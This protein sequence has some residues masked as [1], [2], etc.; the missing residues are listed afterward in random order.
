VASSAAPLGDRR[1]SGWGHERPKDDVCV[2]SVRLP[3]ADIDRRGPWVA[4]VPAGV[5]ALFR[6][7][8]D[9]MWVEGT[10]FNC[11]QRRLPINLHS[12]TIEFPPTSGNQRPCRDAG[13]RAIA[14]GLAVLERAKRASTLIQQRHLTPSCEG[15]A[16]TAERTLDPA[17]MFTESLNLGPEL[18]NNQDPVRHWLN[19][20][21]DPT[22]CCFG[23]HPRCCELVSW[24]EALSI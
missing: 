9:R 18:E 20:H 24:L 4:F 5:V 7:I 11:H 16:P 13:V 21:C 6:K 12:R 23:L 3:T 1:T 17:R 15:N 19:G 14:L 22:H 8:A 10:E 2:E